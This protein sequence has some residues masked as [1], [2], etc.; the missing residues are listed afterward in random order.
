MPATDRLS[1]STSLSLPSTL[2]TIAWSWLV[3]AESATPTG[4]SLTGDTVM[5]TV[6]VDVPPLPSLRV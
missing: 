2:M 6:P 3:V 1:P 5:V 4:A